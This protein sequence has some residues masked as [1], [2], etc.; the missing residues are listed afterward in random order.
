MSKKT[1]ECVSCG[2]FRK[3]ITVFDRSDA[4]FYAC[5]ICF[6]EAQKFLNLAKD[7]PLTEIAAKLLALRSPEKARAARKRFELLLAGLPWNEIEARIEF[8]RK[9][10]AK[11]REE[12]EKKGREEYQKLVSALEEA[13]EEEVASEGFEWELFEVVRSGRKHCI[14]KVGIYPWGVTFLEGRVAEL[15]ECFREIVQEIKKKTWFCPYCNTRIGW[16]EATGEKKC[17]CGAEFKQSSSQTCSGSVHDNNAW[18]EIEK[19]LRRTC[20][21]EDWTVY[22]ALLEGGEQIEELFDGVKYLGKVF[23]WPTYALRGRLSVKPVKQLLE[24][25]YCALKLGLLRSGFEPVVVNRRYVPR[26]LEWWAGKV[27]EI[28]VKICLKHPYCEGIAV[29]P[30]I[31]SIPE[32]CGWHELDEKFGIFDQWCDYLIDNGEDGDYIVSDYV[33]FG[34]YDIKEGFFYR[35]SVPAFQTAEDAVD[36]VF[37]VVRNGMSVYADKVK[38]FRRQLSGG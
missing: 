1:R 3:D 6:A 38:D 29:I 8:L 36:W 26:R 21:G 27:N 33:E 37:G 2:N 31:E 15:R 35:G 23:G 30:D 14:I 5:N 25:E 9:L 28:G 34:A 20:T 10:A 12:A 24:N 17:S 22:E 4:R 13:L 19:K 18:E 16:R 32:R 7:E 11:K